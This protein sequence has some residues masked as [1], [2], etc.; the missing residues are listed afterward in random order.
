MAIDID[1]AEDPGLTPSLMAAAERA[2]TVVG[3]LSYSG[4]H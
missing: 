2:A 1:L 4:N 3:P